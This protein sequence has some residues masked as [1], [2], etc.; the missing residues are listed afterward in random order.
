M[1][2]GAGSGERVGMLEKNASHFSYS[3]DA[4][5]EDYRARCC[6]LTTRAGGWRSQSSRRTS[7]RRTPL[8][9]RRETTPALRCVRVGR[10]VQR[11][12]DG[13]LYVRGSARKAWS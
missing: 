10:L 3:L 6:L 1:Q 7:K 8:A 2:A 4:D 11:F 9:M 5:A 12:V 13:P